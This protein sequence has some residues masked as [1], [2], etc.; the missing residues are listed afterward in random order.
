M[1]ERR[2]TGGGKTGGEPSTVLEAG[3]ESGWAKLPVAAMSNFKC[4]IYGLD[5]FVYRTLP[6][7]VPFDCDAFQER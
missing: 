2:E 7:G 4:N 3:G 6:N 1:E 5:Q